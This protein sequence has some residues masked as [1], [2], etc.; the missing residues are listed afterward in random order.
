MYISAHDALTGGLF[1]HLLGQTSDESRSLATIVQTNAVAVHVFHSLLDIDP[2]DALEDYLDRKRAEDVD[3]TGFMASLE[4]TRC[5]SA[6]RLSVFQVTGYSPLQYAIAFS[7]ESVEFLLADGEDAAAELCLVYA[8]NARQWK[9]IKP[10][11]DAGANVNMRWRGY[12]ALLYACSLCYFNG[13]LELLRWAEDEIDCDA[14]TPDGRNALEV[15]DSAARAGSAADLT[16]SEIDEFRAALVAHVKFVEDE[17][18]GQLDMPG[19]FPD[20]P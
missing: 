10:L 4:D 7:P 16:Q 15:F 12:T 9:L 5:N 13:F 18:G 17:S 2:M 11:L 8:V 1:A 6:G 3:V 20:A 19:A 14:C